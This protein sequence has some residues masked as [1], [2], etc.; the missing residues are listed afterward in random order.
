MRWRGMLAAIGWGAILLAGWLF[1]RDAGAQGAPTTHT[2]FMTA[3]ELKGTTTADKLAA[4]PVNPS[5]LSKGYGFKAQG[6][7]DASDAKK[8]EV[9]SYTLVPAFVT[10]RQG[11]TVTLTVFVVNGD[12]HEVRITDPEGHEVVPKTIWQRGR[13]YHV[14]VVAEKPGTYHL[15]CSAHAPTMNAAVFVLP[16]KE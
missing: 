4:P 13:E 2:I 15:T 11:D 7:A 14:S 6:H 16:R 9:S 8:W 3:I 10:V 5:V 1:A 12:E